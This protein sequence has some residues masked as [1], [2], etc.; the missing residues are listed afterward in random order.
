MRTQTAEETGTV[1]VPLTTRI[2]GFVLAVVVR[3]LCATVRLRIE[4]EAEMDEV[5]KQASGGMFV[6]WHGTLTLCVDHYRGRGYYAMVSQSRDGDLLSEYFR[7]GGM[8]VVRGSTKRGGAVA[9]RQAVNLLKQGG[10]LA[11]TPD[12]PRGPSGVAQPGG[13]YFAMKSGRP[14]IPIGV[15]AR[16]SK[17]LGTWDAHLVPFPFSRAHWVYGDPIWVREGDDLEAARQKLERALHDVQAQAEA[18]LDGKRAPH[19]AHP[20]AK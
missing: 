8:R 2:L 9:A 19:D 3:A 13:A 15:A 6:T 20:A 4:R 14:I 16:P 5:L 10:V 7:Y 12:G 17:R 11:F 18:V 1:S